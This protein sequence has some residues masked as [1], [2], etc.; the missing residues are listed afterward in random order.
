VHAK[1]LRVKYK[2]R[3]KLCFF[4][5]PLQLGVKKQVARKDAKNKYKSCKE[6]GQQKSKV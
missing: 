1:A 5:F 2:R 3:K 4:A 6:F